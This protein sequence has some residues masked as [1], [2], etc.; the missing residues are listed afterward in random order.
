MQA[1]FENDEKRT[2]NIERTQAAYEIVSVIRSDMDKA[3]KKERLEDYHEADIADCLELLTAEERK[4]LYLL[5]D[6]DEVSDIISYADDAAPYIEEMDSKL[7]A[8]V[9]AEMDADDAVDILEEVDGDKKDELIKL[10]DSEARDD[11]RLI[12]S[13]ADDEAGSLLT[14]NFISVR[15]GS[16]VKQAMKTL[17]K[18]AAEN[19]NIS[20][21]YVVDEY[22]KFYGALDLKDLITA[23]ENDNLEEKITTS[24]PFVYADEKTEEFIN[25]IKDYA[26]DSIPVLDREKHILGVITLDDI[27]EV[28]DSEMGE[29]Y[30]RLAGLT[31]EEDL[32]ENVF[33]SMKKRVPWLFALL[34][35]GMVVSSVVGIFEGVVSQLAIVVCFQSLILD[36]AGN[37]G[38]QSLA[39]T[40]RVLTDEKLSRKQLFS[41]V[42]K[43]IKIGLSNG[44]LL[45][46][47]SFAAIGVYVCV[48]KGKTPAFSYAVSACIGAALLLSMAVSSFMGTVIPIFFKSVNIDPAVASGPLIT[49]VNDLVAV[50]AYYGLVWVFLINI[51]QLVE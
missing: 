7:A 31:A 47:V 49:T 28:M 24:Y 40:I 13:F 38:T 23:R 33:E 15:L 14:T 10:L 44:L 5:L 25:E 42:L 20:T 27:I 34:V 39:V 48:F 22:E 19:D 11:I 4:E 16:T 50:V 51:L 41:L 37:V 6:I 2:E 8:D 21:I 45:G 29:D 3:E 32:K 1:F 46:L 26:E 18:E 43:E 30:A 9:I 17:V 12:S 36:M 35:L